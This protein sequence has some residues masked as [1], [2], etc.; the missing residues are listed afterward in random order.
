M[1]L[2][3]AQDL[4]RAR[5]RIQQHDWAKHIFSTVRARA[6]ARRA[7]PADVPALAGGWVHDFVCPTHWN[8]LTFDPN[9]PHAHRCPCGE[10]HTGEKLDAA[11]RVLEHRRIAAASRDLALIF[12][13]TDEP[14]YGEAACRIL[15][16][17]A[18]HY[19]GY[20]GADD[21]R[22]WMLKGRVFNQALTEAIWTV[23]IVHAYDLL[24]GALAPQ[25]DA[26]IVAGLLRPIVATLTRALDNEFAHNPKSNYNAWLIAALG[27]LG[28]ALD[29]RAL[30]ERAVDGPAGFRAH[31]AA[32]ILPDG[33]EY[34]GTPYYHNFVALGYTLLAEAARANGRDL[35]AERG[36]GGQSI[37]AMWRAFTS[38]AFADGTIPA[39]NDGAYYRVGPFAAEICEVYEIAL[40]RTGAPEFAWLLA[41]TYRGAPRDAWSALLF[42]A[43]D[44]ATAPRPPRPSVCLDSVGIAVLRDETHAQEICV[45]FGPHAGSHSHL[46]RLGVQVY[47]WSTDPGTP[48]YGVEARNTW[49]QQ[50]AAHN[51]VVVDGQSQ[52]PCAGQLLNWIVAPESTTLWL[53]ADAAYPGVRLSRL[54]TLNDGVLKDSLLLESEA[55]HTYD[56]LLHVDGECRFDTAVLGPAKS[57]LGDGPY[58]FLAP[59]FQQDSVSRFQFTAHYAGQSLHVTLT[60][61]VRFDLILARSPAHVA[62]PGLPR[63]TILARARTRRAHFVMT[64]ELIR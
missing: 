55:E 11:W 1:S 46:D 20:A 49:Y 36:P 6:D 43:Q 41:Q 58:A 64:S 61:D 21:A 16:R 31:L 27:L 19:N 50:T 15:T 56:W 45:P 59:Q 9:S 8:A 12:A 10:T 33:F 25:A 54:L 5:E 62:T 44:I 47:P 23:P 48:L 35:Y 38:L 51:A 14:D 17:Y 30:V 13:L 2:L 42:A 4:N 37:E 29:D 22:A 24:R 18:E 39:L 53:A 52:A 40:A 57:V 26:R 34:E 60:A 28:Y 3:A 63:Q 32:A 7:Q